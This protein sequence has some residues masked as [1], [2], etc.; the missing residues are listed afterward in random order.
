MLDK[1]SRRRLL[2]Q[3]PCVQNCLGERR[4]QRSEE[5]VSEEEEARRG[6]ETKASLLFLFLL[7]GP[8]MERGTER[9][10]QLIA[11]ILKSWK[12][13]CACLAGITAGP[14]RKGRNPLTSW[15]LRRRPPARHSAGC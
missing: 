2:L 7:L 11:A 15:R 4:T 3:Q 1:V 12:E 14:A 10:T 8:V 6:E 5:N 13:P 9:R